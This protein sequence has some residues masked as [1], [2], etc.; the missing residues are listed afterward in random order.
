MDKQFFINKSKN[1]GSFVSFLRN[2]KNIKYLNFLNNSINI[3][4]INRSIP[5]KLWYYINSVNDIPLCICGEYL[6]FIGFK[7]LY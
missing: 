1:I 7:N 6:S 4:L 5:E 2:P 3:N